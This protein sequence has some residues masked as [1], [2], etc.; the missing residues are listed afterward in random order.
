[1]ALILHLRSA[2]QQWWQSHL[3][4]L[5]PDI[6]CRLWNDPGDPKA[7]EYAVVWRPPQGGLRQFPNLKCIVSVGAGVDHV[8]ADALLPAGVPIIRTTGDDLTLRMREYVCLHVLRLHRGLDAQIDA[9][10][11]ASW[12]Q[13]INPVAYNRRIGIMG[14]GKLGQDAA[15]AL[16]QLGFS[17]SGWARGQ[18]QLAGIRCFAG[19]D[20][21][22]QFLARADILVCLLPLTAQTDSILNRTLFN[23]LPSGASLINAGRGEHL[24]EQDLLDALDSGQLHSA[25]LDVFRQEPLPATHQFWAHAQILVTPHVGSMIDP[26]TGGREIARNLQA[27]INGEPVADLIDSDRG[28]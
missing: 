9:Q 23:Q 20:Q 27:F 8:L 28:Y 7:I 12:Q 24:V 10:Q 1:M 14:L 19:P 11:Q 25:T 15:R 18:H 22:P 3:Q 13:A 17:V 2:R 4:A 5:L 21:L 26:E 16:A 6:E